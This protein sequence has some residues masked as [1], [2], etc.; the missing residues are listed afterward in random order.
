MLAIKLFAVC[1]NRGGCVRQALR[2][3]LIPILM[4]VLWVHAEPVGGKDNPD[5]GA[6]SPRHLP[7]VWSGEERAGK[8]EH[9]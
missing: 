8:C 5:A 6:E 9:F 7:L 2:S 4:E 1:Q 3:F